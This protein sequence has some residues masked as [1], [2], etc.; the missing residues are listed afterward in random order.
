[1]VLVGCGH[2]VTKVR[3]SRVPIRNPWIRKDGRW[4]KRGVSNLVSAVSVRQNGRI[5]PSKTRDVFV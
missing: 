1:M 5:V 3:V 2:F 4:R